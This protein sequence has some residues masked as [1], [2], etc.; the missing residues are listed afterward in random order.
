MKDQSWKPMKET[1]T[2]RSDAAHSSSNNHGSSDCE[3]RATITKELED[4][5]VDMPVLGL[6]GRHF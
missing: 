6:A 3:N 2:T 1:I 4:R 5:L